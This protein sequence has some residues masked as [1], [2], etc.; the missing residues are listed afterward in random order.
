MNE[1][2]SKLLEH[3][4]KLVAQD[5]V[6]SIAFAVIRPDGV[7]EFGHAGASYSLLGATALAK[8]GISSKLFRGSEDVVGHENKEA[9][10]S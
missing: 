10:D 9:M 2:V 6:T 4:G 7:P 1:E 5:Q 8:V 3:L